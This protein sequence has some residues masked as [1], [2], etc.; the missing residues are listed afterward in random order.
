MRRECACGVS[1]KLGEKELVE[2]LTMRRKGAEV[3]VKMHVTGVKNQVRQN[4]AHCEDVRVE[5][6]GLAQNYS[7]DT[8]PTAPAKT[9]HKNKKRRY[10]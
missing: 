2:E 9:K 4:R 7:S 1:L 3:Y 8:S 5:R 10:R 6:E